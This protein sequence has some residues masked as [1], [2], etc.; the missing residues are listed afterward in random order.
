[1]A[2]IQETDASGH[3][4]SAAHRVEQALIEEISAGELLPGVRLD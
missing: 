4:L 1:M 2:N 3:K